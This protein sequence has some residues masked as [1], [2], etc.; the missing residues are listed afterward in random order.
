VNP[1]YPDDPQVVGAFLAAQAEW[2]RGIA[3]NHSQSPHSPQSLGRRLAQRSACLLVSLGGRL[4]QAGLPRY[5]QIETAV[6]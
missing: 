4:V 2:E 1:L 6:R 3:D 5:S